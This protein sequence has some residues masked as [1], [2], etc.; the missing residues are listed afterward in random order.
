[1]ITEALPDVPAMTKALDQAGRVVERAQQEWQAL[2]GAGEVIRAARS[3]VQALQASDAIRARIAKEVHAL[4]EQK[5][6]L[7]LEIEAWQSG[8]ADFKRAV[9]SKKAELQK[10]TAARLRYLEVYEAERRELQGALDALKAEKA[11]ILEQLRPAS[12]RVAEA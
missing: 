3:A 6:A 4:K 1:M 11:A 8:L 10:A 9:E 7:G 5:H 12:L 2:Q